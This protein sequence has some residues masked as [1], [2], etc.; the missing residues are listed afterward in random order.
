MVSTSI[1]GWNA[2]ANYHE[3]HGLGHRFEV[4]LVLVR[5][6]LS[7][8]DSSDDWSTGTDNE[9]ITDNE[10]NH[11]N[12]GKLRRYI[13]PSRSFS[14]TLLA[15]DTRDGIEDGCVSSGSDSVTES[16]AFLFDNEHRT[17]IEDF[18]KL[19]AFL[20]LLV[21]LPPSTLERPQVAMDSEGWNLGRFGSLTLLQIF[22]RFRAHTYVIDI[23]SLGGRK[24]FD[25]EHENGWSLRR[26]SESPDIL[27]IFWD[28]RQDQDALKAHF[29]VELG[30][31]MCLQLVEL[32]VRD[33]G[34]DR[35]LRE[36][37]SRCI[38]LE[39]E[40]WMSRDEVEK[41]VLA[42]VAGRSYF[43]EYTYKVFEQRPL[44]AV[45]LDYAAGDV[46]QMLQL[47]D[48]LYP[49]L[50]AE[51]KE[52]VAAETKKCLLEGMMPD[53]PQGSGLAPQA[54][55]E[56]PI[57]PFVFEEYTG[58]GFDSV[59]DAAELDEDHDALAEES[60]WVLA[61]E[62]QADWEK[63]ALEHLDYNWLGVTLT[64]TMGDNRDSAENFL[65]DRT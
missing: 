29:G 13:S 27:K 61:E 31:T 54:I 10:V 56:L 20:A 48:H 32:V 64:T 40:A 17:L 45:A 33:R 44:P 46:D 42:N 50:T 5:N 37:L 62:E 19:N 16:L 2:V 1:E 23:L 57:I 39:G 49:R 59:D 63:E 11:Q 21:N 12:E 6:T 18:N 7:S 51:G 35:Q 34:R 4:P 9:V 24:A 30:W 58:Q 41:W 47:W 22:L 38:D 8:L 65:S 60:G 26:F 14:L 28:P 36:K 43:Q 3:L 15:H 53:K 52:L 25:Y 55:Q